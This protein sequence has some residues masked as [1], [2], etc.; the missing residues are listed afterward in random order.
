[1]SPHRFRQ[2]RDTLGLTQSEAAKALGIG[3]ST[4]Q[5]YERGRRFDD[6]RPVEIPRT[7]AMACAALEAGLEPLS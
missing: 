7:V 4:L 5:L 2:W 3:L 6:N 1:M